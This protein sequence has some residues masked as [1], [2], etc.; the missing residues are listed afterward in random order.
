MVSFCGERMGSHT[1][2]KLQRW[3]NGV[4]V[5]LCGLLSLFV[6][7]RFY[8]LTSIDHRSL[9]TSSED[10]GRSQ[11]VVLL[12]MFFGL[13]VGILAMQFLSVVGEAIPYTVF[14]FLIGVLFSIANKEDYGNFVFV[15]VMEC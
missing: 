5:G 12:F 3:S 1:A 6:L 8:D 4:V 10:D 7:C 11:T 13:S 2:V 14:V 9:W 15:S